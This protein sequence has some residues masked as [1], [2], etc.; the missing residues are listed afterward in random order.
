MNREVITYSWVVVEISGLGSRS[1]NRYTYFLF[2]IIILLYTITMGPRIQ[3][4]NMQVVV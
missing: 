2:L 3:N 4:P 1:K